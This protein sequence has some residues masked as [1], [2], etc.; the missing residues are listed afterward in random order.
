MA[1]ARLPFLLLVGYAL[2]WLE[3]TPVGLP[4]AATALWVADL[5]SLKE[6]DNAVLEHGLKVPA[7]NRHCEN[8][9]DAVTAWNYALNNLIEADRSDELKST[10]PRLRELVQKF[11][12]T[13]SNAAY[14][15]LTR[16]LR[17]AFRTEPIR[18]FLVAHRS[19]TTPVNPDDHR[20]FNFGRAVVRGQTH[21]ESSD[22]PGSGQFRAAAM[23]HEGQPPVG[24][25]N[26]TTIL[27]NTDVRM[28]LV[29]FGTWQLEGDVCQQ[30]VKWALQAGYRHIDTAQDYANEADVGKAI[31]ESGVPRQEIFLATK[32]SYHADFKP[33]RLLKTFKRQL[34]KLNT[35]YI[36][37]YMLHGPESTKKNAKAW[38]MLEKL[39]NLGKIRAI[40]LSNFD[41][42]DFHELQRAAKIKPAYVQDKWSVYSHSSWDTWPDLP[43][44]IKSNQAGMMGYSVLNPWPSTLAPLEDP[45]VLLMAKRLGV[46]PSQLLHRWTLQLGIGVLPRSKTQDRIVENANLFSFNISEADMHYMSGL[47][48]F[49]HDGI[50]VPHLAH[51][52]EHEHA[53]SE[54]HHEGTED[55][56]HE[57]HHE[58]HPEEHHEEHPDEHHEQHHEEHHEEHPE[59][60]H[61]GHDAEHHEEHTDETADYAVDLDEEQ[62]EHDDHEDDQHHDEEEHDGDHHDDHHGAKEHHD[63]HDDEHGDEHHDVEGLEGEHEEDVEEDLE[64]EEEEDDHASEDEEEEEEDEDETDAYENQRGEDL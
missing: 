56:H 30:A 17:R 37:L 54:D 57:E 11:V 22:G 3:A 19:A 2:P 4:F 55:H 32:L 58:E 40:G 28:P 24:L 64:E 46:T 60:H 9:L 29:G 52:D 34:K 27:G 18:S 47:H 61:E 10:I 33:K 50:R 45:H 14:T 38:S 44:L 51:H 16:G 62:P 39:V 12:E 48:D 36:D 43:H 41:S 7:A 13:P 35:S 20:L 6:C 42:H 26:A 53:G 23:F 5:P 8:P 15:Q 59:E 49:A 1:S 21:G 25:G 63:E 31:S